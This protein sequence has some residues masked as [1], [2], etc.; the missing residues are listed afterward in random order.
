MVPSSA[1]GQR[2]ATQSAVP[3]GRTEVHQLCAGFGQHDV[4][5]FNIA[6]NNAKAVRL[7]ESVGE[8]ATDLYVTCSSGRAPL[9]RR[10]ARRPTVQVLHDQE[11]DIGLVP[12]IK[13]RTDVRVLK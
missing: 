1:V 8:I 2:H 7:G 9:K 3:F 12:R 4:A 10:F 11:E 5:R 13:E 6:M